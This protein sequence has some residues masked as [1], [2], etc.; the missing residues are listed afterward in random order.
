MAL[1]AAEETKKDEA[2]TNVEDPPG[3]VEP[4]AVEDVGLAVVEDVGP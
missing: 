3:D 4:A 2:G 1:C